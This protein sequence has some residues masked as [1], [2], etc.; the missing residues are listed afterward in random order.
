MIPRP[1]TSPLFPYTTLFR[2]IG[3]REL[4]RDLQR[5]IVDVRKGRHRQQR[6]RDQTANQQSYHQQGSRDRPMDEGRGYV[7]GIG[8]C[9]ALCAI[10][11]CAALPCSAVTRVPGCSLYCPS[12]TTCSL[13]FRPE[14]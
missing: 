8:A 5:R 14:S 1:P 3:A 4:G 11:S 6:I 7:H 9:S 12:T 10:A 2:S 13:A